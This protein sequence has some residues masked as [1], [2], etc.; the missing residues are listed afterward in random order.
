MKKKLSTN[1]SHFFFNFRQSRT[2][3]IRL[4]NR[5]SDCESPPPSRGM[6]VV[7]KF[8][9]CCTV[10]PSTFNIACRREGER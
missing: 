2:K 7:I 3:I 4:P 10:G 6:L 1:P 5:K 9:F 8:K